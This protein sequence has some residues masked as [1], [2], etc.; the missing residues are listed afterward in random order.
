MRTCF[1]V[2]GG[3]MNTKVATMVAL[4]ISL[5]FATGTLQAQ[6]WCTLQGGAWTDPSG[7]VCEIGA[8]G[9]ARPVPASPYRDQPLPQQEAVPAPAINSQAPVVVVPVAPISSNDV[10]AVA[11]NV[12][13][14]TEAI[15][16]D[17][18]SG[19]GL[20]VFIIIGLIFAGA[21]FGW[22]ANK[23]FWMGLVILA[24]GVFTAGWG[25]VALG[26]CAA[27]YLFFTKKK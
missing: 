26:V 4:I 23:F 18:D 6:G 19:M 15:G 7:L 22:F 9:V 25:I 17:A 1:I 2:Q 21:K 8:D 10:P 5:S 16:L 20:M 27:I 11:N 3:N 24:I 12:A 13:A 14:G